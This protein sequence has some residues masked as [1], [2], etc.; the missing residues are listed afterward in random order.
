MYQ[1]EM[2]S[3]NLAKFLSNYRYVFVDTCSLMEDS[4][5]KFMDSLTASK[6]YWNEELQIIILGECIEELK[7]H[8]KNKEDANVRIS[9]TRALKII[10]HDKRHTKAFTITKSAKNSI[11]F[12]DN[13]IFTNVSSLRIQNKILV[14]TQDKKLTT[15]LLKLN[16]LD[17]QKGRYLDVYR[18]NPKSDLEMNPGEFPAKTYTKKQ[19]ASSFQKL[20]KDTKEKD[21]TAN[22]KEEPSFNE[23]QKAVLANDEK[24]MANLSNSTYKDENKI[25]DIDAQLK[26]IASL[27]SKEFS[28]L[29]LKL[30]KVDL[31]KK[32][33][34]LIQ[35][36]PIKKEE[37]KK[38]PETKP[39]PQQKEATL[40]R[41]FGQKPSDALRQLAKHYHSIVRDSSIDYVAM[42]HGE[43]DLTEED[44]T[45]VDSLAFN[46]PSFRY[47]KGERT[48]LFNKGKDF[49]VSLEENEPI[50]EINKPTPAKEKP[51]PKQEEPLSKTVAKK[52]TKQTVPAPKKAAKKS[53]SQEKKE[54]VVDPNKKLKVR[55]AKK[56]T[57]DNQEV[58]DVLVLVPSK[59][60]SKKETAKKKI[61]PLKKDNDPKKVEEALS[62]DKTLNANVHNPNYPKEKA[63]AD[64]KAQIAR[65][66]ALDETAMKGLSLKMADLKKLEK[67]LH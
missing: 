2:K 48:Y 54:P 7:K 53:V 17:S 55:K 39:L 52:E 46:A 23:A 12:A 61:V 35:K 13:A 8:S 34:E 30:S 63:L 6:E 22:K 66:A 60:A 33:A 25:R 18:I 14:I 47:R 64:V 59:P 29:Q 45:K 4:F 65:L 9:A 42:V 1:E 43:L 67:S 37:P 57:T 50:K 19:D 11:A 21:K 44:L 26:R 16:R 49:Q 51:Q 24:L 41:E 31:Q 62:A 15:D 32:K 20:E 38:I 28:S 40:W 5:P 36:A 58:V 56:K 10:R 3:S 27:P